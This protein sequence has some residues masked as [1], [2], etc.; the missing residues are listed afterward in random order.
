M[1]S[2]LYSSHLLAVCCVF[3]DD[4]RVDPYTQATRVMLGDEYMLLLWKHAGNPKRI[5]DV[6]WLKQSRARYR[7]AV[8]ICID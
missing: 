1:C 8:L 6:F 3:G 2:V 4:C 7:Q 5:C